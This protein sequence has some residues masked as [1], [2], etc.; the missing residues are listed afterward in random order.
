MIK[1]LS[2]AL[3]LLAGLVALPASVQAHKGH[4][5]PQITRF[6]FTDRP[7][8]SGTLERL[9][10]VAHD[11]NSWISEIQIQWEDPEQAGGVIFAHTYCVQDPEFTT[12]GTPAKLKI[13]V[14]FDHPANYHVEARAISEKRCEGGNDTLFSKTR[15]MDITVHDPHKAFADPDDIAGPLDVVSAEQTLT[16]DDAGL[17]NYIVHTLVM[18]SDLGASPLAAADDYLEF[19]FDTDGDPSTIERRLVVDQASDGTLT[20][21]IKNAGGTVVGQGTI[22]VDGASLSVGFVKRLLGR[23]VAAYRWYATS[24]DDSSPSCLQSVCDDRAPDSGTYSHRL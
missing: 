10:V 22:T 20:A 3:L 12:P 14:T 13:D 5:R 21:E 8:K 18:S 17:D 24:H 16:S 4:A 7:L 11:P 6:E 19:L 2:V 9:V 15:E 23:G 1:R